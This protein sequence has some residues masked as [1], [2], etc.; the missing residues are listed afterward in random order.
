M[1]E[2]AFKA[3]G[4]SWTINTESEI[5]A[6]IKS[7]VLNRVEIFEQNYSRFRSNSLISEISQKAGS[8]NLP[9]DAEKLF[10]VYKK[11]YEATDEMVT[12]LM[13]KVLSD[14]GYDSNYS[15]KPKEEV[16]A[17]PKWEDAFEYNHPTLVLKAPTQFDFGAAGK[18]YLV[19]LVSEI[20]ENHKIASYMVNAGG[21]IRTRGRLIKVGL[22]N[23]SNT[24]EAVGVTEIRNTSICGSAGNRRAWDK[25]THIINPKTAKSPTE[26]IAVWVVAETTIL[27]DGLTTALFFT[28]PNSLKNKFNF[29][30]AIIYKNHSLDHSPNFPGNFFTN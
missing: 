26:I 19:D 3:I 28:D 25:Y 9:D 6:E 20:L 4:T 16:F 18:G 5:T 2:F 13:G 17:A 30:Y 7:E 12:P 15:L 1:A 11:L 22:E 10:S 23:P 29:E 14:A 27:A 24:T 21:D 8:Y